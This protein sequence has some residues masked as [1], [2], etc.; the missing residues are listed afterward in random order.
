MW[1]PVFRNYWDDKDDQDVLDY[2]Y[3]QDNQE[4]KNVYDDIVWT[5]RSKKIKQDQLKSTEINLDKLI[6]IKI[7][8]TKVSQG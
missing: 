5:T 4:N 3:D 2:Q 6:P 1:W 8:Q 7:N